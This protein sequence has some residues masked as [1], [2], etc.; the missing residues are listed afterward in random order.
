MQTIAQKFLVELQKNNIANKLL[1]NI[2]IVKVKKVWIEFTHIC[3]E[4]YSPKIT[5]ITFLCVQY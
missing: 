1:Q 4:F 3:I 5:I 2:Q